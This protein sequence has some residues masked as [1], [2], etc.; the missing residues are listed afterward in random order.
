MIE[1][2]LAENKWMKRRIAELEH[3][4]KAAHE[5]ADASEFKSDAKSDTIAALR[6]SNKLLLAENKRLKVCGSCHFYGLLGPDVVSHEDC[7]RM[8]FHGCDPCHF[9]PSRWMPYWHGDQEDEGAPCPVM[10]AREEAT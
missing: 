6:A 5:I 4:V 8:L 7:R 9:T 2:L 10:A 3:N 1:D